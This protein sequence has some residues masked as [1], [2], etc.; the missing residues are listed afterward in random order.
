M[1][2]IVLIFSLL[3]LTVLEE[4]IVSK[5]KV[6]LLKLALFILMMIAGTRD[7]FD[8]NTDAHAYKA[9]YDATPSLFN[10]NINSLLANYEIGYI[11]IN[12]IFKT[13][14]C[15]FNVFCLCN[16]IFFFIAMY[17][18]LKDYIKDNFI[19]IFFFLYKYFIYNNFVS[20]RQSIAIAIFFLIFKYIEKK[21]FKK[22]LFFSICAGLI[23]S[24]AFILIPV[25]FINKINLNKQLFRLFGI[26]LVPGIIFNILHINLLSPFENILINLPYINLEKVSSLTSKSLE[27]ISLIHSLEFFVIF[28][29]VAYFYNVS[30]SN[31]QMKVILCIFLVM[32]L[33][34]TYFS[35]VSI[36]TRVKD[37]FVFTY[38]ILLGKIVYDLPKRNKNRIVMKNTIILYCIL[39]FIRYL[40]L[41]NSGA[42]FNYSSWL[43]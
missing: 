21:D 11:I 25:Y 28:G 40:L 29:I 10:F 6:K 35:G 5:D 1:F 43:F 37:Y 9:I 39:C 16:N 15:S 22:Y 30:F 4:Y 2:W 14:D 41:F 42:Y 38:P 19:F 20:M 23:H 32:G 31:K 3:S 24:S 8:Y 33:I 13:L 18:G 12:S 17:I 7:F 26:C 27:S 36:L 34:V